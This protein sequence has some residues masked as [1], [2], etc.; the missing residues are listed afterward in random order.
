MRAV[1][2]YAAAAF[3]PIRRLVSHHQRQAGND[4]ESFSLAAGVRGNREVADEKLFN[5]SIGEKFEPW[6]NVAR[7]G[8]VF[9]FLRGLNL[10]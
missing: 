6:K 1:F 7:L 9:Y 4:A 2:L 8:G 3:F 5:L 10:K